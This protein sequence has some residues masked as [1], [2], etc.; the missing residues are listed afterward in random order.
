LSKNNFA[1]SNTKH[2]YIF[3]LNLFSF[4]LYIVEWYNDVDEAKK[5]AAENGKPIFVMIH[6]TWCGA[7]KALKKSFASSDAIA[8]AAKDFVMV[9]LEDDDEP[10]GKEWSPDGLFRNFVVV[11]VVVVLFSFSFVSNH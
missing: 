8:N 11:F 9:N 2:K 5:V 7:C 1:Y 3:Y 10:K 6:K 4:S